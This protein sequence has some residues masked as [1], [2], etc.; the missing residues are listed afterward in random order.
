MLQTIEEWQDYIGRLAGA[1]LRSKVLAANSEEFVRQMRDEGFDIPF[2][3]EIMLA[4]VRQLTLTGGMVPDNDGAFDLVDLA[5]TDPVCI[6]TIPMSS[7]QVQILIDD[8][9]EEP[10]DEV[11]EMAAEA[12]LDDEWGETLV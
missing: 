8:P 11:D 6:K 4:F 5:E 3:K 12:D 7:D 2:I 1:P 9:P 10:P